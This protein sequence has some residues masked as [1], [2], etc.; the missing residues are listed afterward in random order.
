MFV[1]KMIASAYN[2]IT[3]KSN[4]KN[5]IDIIPDELIKKI[6]SNFD[7]N[8]LGVL[9]KVCSK[10]NKLA[11]CP[12]LLKTVIYY[13]VATV[14][15]EQ[16]SAAIFDTLRLDIGSIMKSNKTYRLIY[17]PPLT[18][19]E[20]G[21]HLKK[22]F[23]NEEGYYFIEDRVRKLYGEKIF[24]GGWRLVGDVIPESRSLTYEQQQDILR[25]LGKK[26]NAIYEAPDLS[27]AILD[28]LVKAGVFTSGTPTFIPDMI[29]S[30]CKESI[31]KKIGIA[32]VNV[33]VDKKGVMVVSDHMPSYHVGI[34]PVRKL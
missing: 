10:W 16:R 8:V 23:P 30:N 15:F 28:V 17:E 14:C 34:Q 1:P 21:E 4:K 9:P 6:F 33:G 7:L 29:C 19:K 13:K 32:H 27:T 20:L 18:I 2:R 11:N 3:S 31:Q 26:A 25:E 12:L 24:Q 5:T 22:Y